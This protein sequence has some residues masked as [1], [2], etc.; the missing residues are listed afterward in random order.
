MHAGKYQLIA[1]LL[2]VALSFSLPL[3]AVALDSPDAPPA[4]PEEA[5]PASVMAPFSP[6]EATAPPSGTQPAALSDPVS[7]EAPK[8]GSILPETLS[9]EQASKLVFKGAVAKLDRKIMLECIKLAR[10]NAEYHDNVNRKSFAQEWLYPMQREAGT[11]LAFS[12]T[13]VDIRQRARGLRNPSLVSRTAQKKGLECAIVGQAITG[14]SSAVQLLQNLNFTR[15]ASKNGFSP[16]ASA[17]V[18]KGYVTTID[19][20]LAERAQLLAGQNLVRTKE[21]YE[22]QGRLLTHIKNQLIFEY[23]NWSVG[24]RFTEW[25]ENTFYAIDSA[26]GFTQMGS[27]LC[28]LQGFSKRD[29][30]GGAAITGL[31]GNALVTCN[32]IIRTTVGHVV[33]KIERRRLDKLFPQGPR[34]SID[35]V[36]SEWSSSADPRAVDDSSPLETKELAF[37]IRRTEELDGPLD[38]EVAHVQQL[39]RIA[40]QQAISGPLIGL[41][42]VTR[43]VMNTIAYYQNSPPGS[44]N[45]ESSRVAGNKLNLSGRIVQSTGQAYSLVNTPY[46]EVKHYL[47]YRRLKKAN[48]SPKQ[49]LEQR[50]NRLAELEKRV[51]ASLY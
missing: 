49:L 18:V 45:F 34:R 22:L 51:K 44:P 21:L 33:A 16:A 43:S 20:M 9:A 12:N 3:A 42:G 10:Y 50:L 14:T 7:S 35:E 40:D 46:T 4:P 11:A 28:S 27:S 13:I 17:A 2:A 6:S 23:K 36:L 15:V 39:R 24:S 26:Q 48:Q 30:S 47:Y 37:L 38:K 5:G 41:T 32:P 31:V 8:P 19:A 1:G 25:S 29:Y